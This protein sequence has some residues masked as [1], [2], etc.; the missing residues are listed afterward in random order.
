MRTRPIP[1]FFL[2]LILTLAAMP[3]VAAIGP[4]KPVPVD[5]VGPNRNL[6]AT[7]T[8]APED[9]QG[10][11]RVAV[12]PNNPSQVVAAA[13]TWDDM[14]GS[15]G[16]EGLQAAFYSSDGGA[17]WGYSCPPDAPAYGLTCTAVT[18]GSD[19]AL[20]WNDAGEVFLEYVLICDDSGNRDYATVVA[21]STDGGASWSAQGAL[22]SGFITVGWEHS[23]ASAVDNHSGSPYYGRHYTCWIRSNDA[24]SAWSDDN[25]ATWNL[26]DLPTTPISGGMT[27]ADVACELAVE[28]DGTVHV[29]YDTRVCGYAYCF[30]ERM[31]YSRSTDGG[32]SWS[33]AVEVVDFNLVTS[34]G[35]NRPEAQNEHGIG[36]MG[37]IDVDNSGGPC[38]GTLYASFG[39]YGD[40]YDVNSTDIGVVRSSDGGVTW[41]SGVK[42][43]DDT[44][45]YTVQFHP[46][47]AVDQSNGKVIVVWHDARND[48]NNRKIDFFLARSVDCGV[49]FKT[50]VQVSK[51][52]AEFNN[53]TISWSDLNTTD[54]PN[55]NPNQF[56]DYMGLDVVDGTAYVAW[57]DSRHYFPDDGAP[58]AIQVE[59]VGFAKV[60]VLREVWRD[61]P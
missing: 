24:K 15:C 23:P 20:H 26:V 59:N 13:Q 22:S 57:T 14:G 35:A 53:S 1:V 31:F 49:S 4:P 44:G 7:F 12:N 36:P 6:A 5:P 37:A 54:N 29:I 32:A 55:A 42:V 56:G 17:T 9:Y 52:S 50:N 2:C 33:P 30:D 38:D 43:N 45:A 11:V 21:R 46:F 60:N 47:L 61:Q 25:G 10:Q 27:R 3:L 34:S 8:P 48:P 19:S 28:D 58:S 18:Y 16:D 39:D 41:S 40:L 51:P